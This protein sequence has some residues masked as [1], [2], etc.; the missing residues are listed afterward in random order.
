MNREAGSRSVRTS[1]VL[2]KGKR[3]ARE[4]TLI[5]V[6]L[7]PEYAV[8]L[9][10]IAEQA[11]IQEDVLAGFLLAEAIDEAEIDARSIVEILNGIPGA[12]ER[13]ELGMLE[14]GAGRGIPLEDL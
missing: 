3:M 14:L 10:A 5:S 13:T 9:A 12:F 7:E 4:Q 2:E 1:G 6:T 8:R 11:H